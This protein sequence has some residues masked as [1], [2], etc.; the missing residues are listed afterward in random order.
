VAT[1]AEQLN[2]LAANQYVLT[3][4][5]RLSDSRP[6][7]AGSSNYIQNNA[8]T[9]QNANFNITGDGTVGKLGVGVTPSYGLDV[10]TELVAYH[11]IAFADGA[12]RWRLRSTANG[13]ETFQVYSHNNS[14]VNQTRV[15][16]SDSGDMGVGTAAPAARLHAEATGGDAIYAHNVTGYAIHARSEQ[17]A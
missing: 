7:T 1:N 11:D 17:K 3:T 4:D 16:V 15:I 12:H 6:P 13:L 10:N 8:G 9:A 5:P 14:L 2:G